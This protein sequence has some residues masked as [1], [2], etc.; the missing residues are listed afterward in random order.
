MR[1]IL[2]VWL[3]SLLL[4]TCGPAQG[5]DDVHDMD[6]V[7]RREALF[8]SAYEQLDAAILERLLTDD[9]VIT[10]AQ[11]A[12]TKD[13][14]RFIGELGELRSVFPNLQL[15]VDSSSV[16]AGTEP[17]V[18]G[19]RTF[20]WTYAGEPGSYQEQFRHHWQYTEGNWLLHRAE[21]LPPPPQ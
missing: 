17:E 15:S 12:T 4:C 5:S 9:F 16:V 7:Q 20:S 11:P 8:H 6:A 1:V 21:V 2:P 13:K 3:L 14:E 10:Y 18:A 19:L